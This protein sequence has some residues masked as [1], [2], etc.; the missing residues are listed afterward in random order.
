[1]NP[2]LPGRCF[3]NRKSNLDEI[4][5]QVNAT[6]QTLETRQFGE[7]VRNQIMVKA[8]TAAQAFS[9]I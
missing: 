3:F 6:S 2:Q 1:M 8:D 5:E 9:P 7:E 4:F